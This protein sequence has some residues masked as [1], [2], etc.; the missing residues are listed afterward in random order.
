MK[1]LIAH[2]LTTLL[3]VMAG[4]AATASAQS[5]P[6]KV[7]KVH[8]PFEFNLGDKTFPAGDYSLT[9]PMQNLLVLRDSNDYPVAQVLTVGM[10]LPSALAST[11]L[12]FNAS[13]GRYALAEVWRGDE[14]TGQKLFLV[15]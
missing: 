11:K 14:Q 3:L 15:K 1:H 7:V 9:E 5:L 12:K 8:I 4:L 10:D 13:N 6:N 2:T